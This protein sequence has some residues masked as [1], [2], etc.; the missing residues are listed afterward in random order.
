MAVLRLQRG[1][2]YGPILSRRL[3]RSLGINLL[4]LDKKICTF[5]C[6]Y[7]QYGYTDKSVSIN[8]S[9]L[10][11]PVTEILSALEA[12]L[13]KPHSLDHITF[14]GNGEPTLH[15]QF[16]EIIRGTKMLRDR[17][18]PGTLIAV[19]T[20]GS[21]VGEAKILTALNLVDKPMMKLDAGD[22]TCFQKIN[23]PIIN[24]NFGSIIE[25]YQHINKCS[26]QTIFFGGSK[27]NADLP[28]IL[29]WIDLIN[30]IKPFEVQI[31]TT[32][33]PVPDLDVT[34]LP[35]ETLLNIANLAKEKTGLDVNV[36]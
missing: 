31:Y 11:P 21:M 8:N 26:T 10:Y 14:S 19:L 36:Y 28:S 15:P 12:F 27:G 1:I 4:S 5:N 7:C 34:S 23:D 30:V 32:E 20:N 18:K 24:M 22:V 16:L 2:I 3:G 35:H 17:Y 13:K 25:G 6:I 33:R 9:N 29:K